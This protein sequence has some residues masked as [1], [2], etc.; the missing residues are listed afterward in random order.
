[1]KIISIAVAALALAIA[2]IQAAPVPDG[3]PV[4]FTIYSNGETYSSGSV[5]EY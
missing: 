4:R 3:D 2:T 5:K 1:M